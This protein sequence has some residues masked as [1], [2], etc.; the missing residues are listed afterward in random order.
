V[1]AI[2]VWSMFTLLTGL[3]GSLG[4]LIAIRVLFGFGEGIEIGPQFK[5]IGDYFT[6]KERSQANSIFLSALALGPAIATPVATWL[7]GAHG[8]RAMFFA[9]SVPG[10]VLAV[11]L[12][13]LLPKRPP[14]N[15]ES[16]DSEHLNR[17]GLGAS[18][19]NPA[20]WCCGAAYFFFN[21]TFWGFLSW[22]RWALQAHCPMCSAS[23]AW[24]ASDISG[25]PSWRIGARC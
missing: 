21:A 13:L 5:L 3:A 22:G 17:S 7:I 23:W 20:A 8:W 24:S 18:L 1:A 14:E 15:P 19:R 6:T 16:A 12:F 2:L 9:F 25:R 10:A 4:M 11:V